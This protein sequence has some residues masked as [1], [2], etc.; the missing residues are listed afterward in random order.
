MLKEIF[1]MVL[2]KYVTTFS[3]IWIF[4]LLNVL[5]FDEIACKSLKFQKTWKFHLTVTPSKELENNRNEIF[6]TMKKICKL[7]R[8]VSREAI[9]FE[10]SVN[11]M[12]G[13]NKMKFY[14]PWSFLLPR[15]KFEP[16][17]CKLRKWTIS[18]ES[19]MNFGEK[20]WILRESSRAKCA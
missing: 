12:K 6:D 15:Y 1:F 2:I 18:F 20:K 5:D 19:V 14:D 7:G 4:D 3:L 8:F 16:R 17:K 13:N 9:R 11:F 10:S